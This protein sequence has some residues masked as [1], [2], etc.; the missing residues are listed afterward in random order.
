MSAHPPAKEARGGL[1]ESGTVPGEDM[2]QGYHHA[3][4]WGG[5][6]CPPPL[7]LGLVLLFGPAAAEVR[8]SVSKAKSKADK[9]VRPTQAIPQILVSA[10]VS[11]K[12][13]VP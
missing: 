6:S 7:T 11:E 10:N 8:R 1:A 4:V 13:C 2:L 3:P 5:H 12:E 9:S